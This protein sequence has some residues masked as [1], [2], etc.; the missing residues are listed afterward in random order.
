[1]NSNEFL[2][3]AIVLINELSQLSNVSIDEKHPLY[4]HLVFCKNALNNDGFIKLDSNGLNGKKVVKILLDCAILTELTGGSLKQF[5]LGSELPGNREAEKKIRTRVTIS[6][7]YSGLIVELYVFSWNTLNGHNVEIWEEKGLPDI[8]V[9]IPDV[10]NS[11]LIACTHRDNSNPPPFVGYID[12]AEKQIGQAESKHGYQYWGVSLIDV[13]IPVGSYTVDSDDLPEKIISY[14]KSVGEI[15]NSGKYKYVKG[16]ILVWD[17]FLKNEI[18]DNYYCCLRR[19]STIVSAS[20][21]EILDVFKGYDAFAA[22]D[23]I[24]NSA[25]NGKMVGYRIKEIRLSKVPRSYAWFKATCYSL[26]DQ[27]IS[28]SFEQP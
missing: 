23:K 11:F 14:S 21:P 5:T 7:Q 4:E 6:E 26:S 8:K 17:D 2:K 15:L 13:S 12:K 3:S 27:S 9:T 25:Q 16:V 19:R 1:M 20:N 10:A 22:L 18:N 24:E 28:F